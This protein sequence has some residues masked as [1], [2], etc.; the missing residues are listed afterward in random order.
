MFLPFDAGLKKNAKVFY[1]GKGHESTIFFY[2][3]F[4]VFKLEF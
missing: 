1:T 4:N 3:L 2:Y